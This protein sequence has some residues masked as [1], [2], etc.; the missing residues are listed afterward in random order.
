MNVLESE[1][2][3]KQLQMM[4]FQ[5]RFKHLKELEKFLLLISHSKSYYG[6]IFCTIRSALTVA[7]T[8][9]KDDTAPGH[10]ST[11]VNTKTTSTN[12]FGKKKLH[13]MNGTQQSLSLLKQNLQHTKTS[14][15]T[16]NNSNK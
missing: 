5:P 9:G 10:P 16:K 4:N 8:L 13:F 12:I 3:T 14:R 11:S 15:L 1:F 7:I 6:S 2:N